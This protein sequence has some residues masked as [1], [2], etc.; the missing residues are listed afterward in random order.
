MA[1]PIPEEPPV[2]SALS[3]VQE[4]SVNNSISIIPLSVVFLFKVLFRATICTV[5][6]KCKVGYNGQNT[7]PKEYYKVQSND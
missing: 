6:D 1:A 5:C 3:Y 2:T 4:T 7:D